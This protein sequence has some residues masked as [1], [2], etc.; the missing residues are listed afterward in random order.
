MHAETVNRNIVEVREVDT[1]LGFE[2]QD[3]QEQEEKSND[4]DKA[5]SS[6]SSS[7]FE[8][9]IEP[10]QLAAAPV[11]VPPCP[12]VPAPPPVPTPKKKNIMSQKTKKKT[13]GDLGLAEAFDGMT[14]GSGFQNPPMPMVYGKFTKT[15]TRKKGLVRTT[16]YQPY[17]V[18]RLL[19]HAC[20]SKTQIVLKMSAN[21]RQVGV[22]FV[23]P[24]W[25]S[26]TDQHI[27]FGAEE[28]NKEFQFDSDHQIFISMVRIFL[29]YYHIVLFLPY[30]T[31]TFII[32]NTIQLQDE[33]LGPKI[34]KDPNGGAHRIVDWMYF[35]FEEEMKTDPD[36]VDISILNVAISEDDIDLKK[37]D[38]LPP[39]AYDTLSVGNIVSLFETLENGMDSSAK[40]DAWKAKLA[41]GDEAKKEVQEEMLSLI[42]KSRSHTVQVLQLIF[43]GKDMPE[44]KTKTPQVKVQNAKLGKFIIFFFLLCNVITYHTYSL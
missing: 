20:V 23:T 13:T 31:L 5:S 1:K 18:L 42:H 11:P 37:G 35:D 9:D 30:L 29:I 33:N 10:R 25:F 41:A 44:E 27:G 15:R 24:S 38:N 14:M 3:Y 7:S 4:D 39:A 8:F 28:K 21:G 22:G 2:K 36:T 12:V 32:I 6:S 34:T 26:D 19:P 16:Y 43:H 40:V 17:V